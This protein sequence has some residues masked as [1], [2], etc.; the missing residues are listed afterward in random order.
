MYQVTIDDGDDIT[1]LNH[2][3]LMFNR[4]FHSMNTNIHT[5][6]LFLHPAC[7]NLAV[8]QVANGRTF[9]FMCKVTLGLVQQWGWS[10]LDAAKVIDD[11]KLY[12][13]RQAPFTGQEKNSLAWWQALPISGNLRPLKALAI[14]VFSIVPHAGDVE[15]LFSD[16]GG[17]QGTRRCNLT[18]STFET[19][20]KLHA[21]YMR[22]LHDRSKALGLPLR[23]HHAHMHT[24][25]APGINS[26]LAE[27]LERTFSWQPPLAAGSLDP[28]ALEGPETITMEDID[29]AFE[30]LDH[31]TEGIVIDPELENQSSGVEPSTV[32]PFDE[33]QRIDDGTAPRLT[34]RL[35]SMGDKIAN[36]QAQVPGIL[37]HYLYLKAL[38]MHRPNGFFEFPLYYCI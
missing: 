28:D 29:R 8:S 26:D 24:R 37:I 33:L 4:E 3:K 30:E 5:L 17:I 18:V 32:Y 22:H 23:R 2:A 10:E 15:R 36:R 31:R 25:S 9:E 7:C 34:T 13:Q 16:L 38:Q 11:M 12:Y 19:L 6:A 20:G 35:M 27:D 21:N 14:V 1:F